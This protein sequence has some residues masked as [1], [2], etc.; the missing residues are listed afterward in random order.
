MRTG[1]RILQLADVAQL[2]LQIAMRFR[3]CY[4]VASKAVLIG[5]VIVAFRLSI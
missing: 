3:H 4:Q 5:I 1:V 2:C